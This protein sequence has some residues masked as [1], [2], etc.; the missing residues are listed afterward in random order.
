MDLA[1]QGFLGLV[2]GM[3][4]RSG[5]SNTRNSAARW[6]STEQGT[7]AEVVSPS[8][9]KQSNEALDAAPFPSASFS[10]QTL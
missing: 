8:W 2:D 10:C 5:G 9:W 1:D 6:T 3:R 4:T 7:L